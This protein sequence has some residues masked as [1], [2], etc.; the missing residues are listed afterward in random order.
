VTAALHVDAGRVV[1]A[2]LPHGA[3]AFLDREWAPLDHSGPVP[4]IVVAGTPT[5]RVDAAAR[6]LAGIAAAAL[7]L[8]PGLPVA[9][10]GAGLV[11]ATAR[12]RLAAEGRLAPRADGAPAAVIETT[13]DPAEIA[14]ALQR[15]R[16]GGTVVL[17]G[18][19]LSR[20]YDLDLYP[21]V[22]V[23]GLRLVGRGPDAAVAEV[24]SAKGLQRLAPG[25]RLDAEML[26]HCVARTEAP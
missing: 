8:V 25:E 15:V 26:W 1:A 9:V 19:P 2:E 3:A 10:T 17:S 13:G 21:D 14:A 11:A 24:P 6:Q 7:A 18:E 22:H 5:E 23:R 20:R 16:D 12:R 4:A